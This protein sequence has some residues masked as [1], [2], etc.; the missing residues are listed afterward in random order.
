[1]K[2]ILIYFMIAGFTAALFGAT[3]AA[4]R[5]QAYEKHLQMKHNSIF[6]QLEWHSLG[7]YF[8]GGRIDDIEA[9][10]NNPYTFYVAS[11]SGG[12]WIT[13]NN[14]NTWEPVFD[15]ESSIS[16]GDIAISQGNRNLVWVGTGEANSSRSSYAGTGVFKSTD[17]GKTWQNMGLRESHHI[18]RILI[19]PEDNKTVYAAALGHLY[20]DNEERGVFKTTDGGKTWKKVLYISPKTGVVDLIMHPRNNKILFA[21]SWQKDRK[22]WEMIEG[23]EESAIYKTLDGGLTWT[24]KVNGF[25]QH[26]N[27]GRVGLAISPSN[28]DV[29]YALLDNQENRP[30][31]KEDEPGKKS[32]ITLEDLVRMG[33]DEFIKIDTR[34]LAKFLKENLAATFFDAEV[35][36]GLVKAGEITPTE[37]AEIITEDLEKLNLMVVGAEVYRSSDGGESWA[38]TYK[39]NLSSDIYKSYGFYFGQIRVDPKDE[40]TLYILGIPLLKSGNGGRT[41]ENISTQGNMLTRNAVHVDSHAMWIDPKDPRRILLGTDGGLNISYDAGATW[42]KVDNLCLAQCYTV[43]YDFRRP[44]FIYTGLQDNGVTVGPRNFR[45]GSR[46]RMWRMILGADGASVEVQK[47]DPNIVYAASQFGAIYRVDL[48]KMSLKGIKPGSKTRKTR[49]RFN[50]LAPFIISHHDSSTIYMGANVLFKSGDKGDNWE[51]LSP[52]LSRK[53]NIDG[54]VPY[55]TI[56][57]IAESTF[58]PGILY[59]GTDDGNVWLTRNGGKNWKNIGAVLPGKWVSRVV[60]SRY[61]KERIYVTMTGY[62]EDD[63]AT[64]IYVSHD[65]GA[66]WQFLKANLPD[67]PVNVIREDPRND[68]ILYTGTDSGVYISLNSGEKWRSLKCNLPTIAVCDLRIHPREKELIIGT[69]GRG[70]FVLPVKNIQRLTP[71]VLSRPLFLFEIESV[72]LLDYPPRGKQKIKFEFYT[73]KSTKVTLQIMKAGRSIKRL[74]IDSAPGLNIFE[75]DMVIDERKKEKIEPGTYRV[76]ARSAR[77]KIER[78]LKITEAGSTRN[79]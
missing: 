33:V 62:R 76:T 19:D 51:A 5:R 31:T 67:E 3:S 60:A 21:A 35:L 71:Q 68:N 50:W 34:T 29:L 10:E 55:G 45:Y 25:P 46:S 47:D 52:D 77:T 18:G 57:T 9:Y 27:V 8:T 69:H 30:V 40:N 23:G 44:Y 56:T 65:F 13:E 37:L 38:K 72:H 15:H 2:K 17:G 22:P 79:P 61:K 6:K 16:I 32:G 54:N 41:F 53:K 48:G 20:T 63:F 73:P 66:N 58:G 59:A 26:G 43:N 78:T 11:A 49:Y 1:M 75:W 24:K 36:K 28:P 7:P 4:E 14:A 70:V 64:Y 74:N 12:L 39:Q 42:Q